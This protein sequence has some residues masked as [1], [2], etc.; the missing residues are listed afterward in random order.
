M[1]VFYYGDLFSLCQLRIFMV[2]Y[3]IVSG[4]PNAERSLLLFY[5]LL[6][7]PIAPHTAVTLHVLP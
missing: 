2:N 6:P 4:L 7:H 3:K 5:T 1:N